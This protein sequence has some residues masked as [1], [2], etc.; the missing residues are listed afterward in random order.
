[1]NLHEYQGKQLFKE[2]GLPVSEGY[3]ADT[4]QG[5]VEAAETRVSAK[6]HNISA[7]TVVFVQV[8]VL[9]RPDFSRPSNTDLGFIDDE[10]N[11]LASGQLPQL[12]V[13]GG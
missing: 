4:A 13:V 6:S 2:Y 10:G 11:T 3:A 12:F 1:M 7:A 5:A 8:P 9:V